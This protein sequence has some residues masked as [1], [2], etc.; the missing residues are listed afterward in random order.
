MGWVVR[1][2]RIGGIGFLWPNDDRELHLLTRDRK[3]GDVLFHA[4]WNFAETIASKDHAPL[5]GAAFCERHTGPHDFVATAVG[6]CG[7]GNWT[8]GF[9]GEAPVPLTFRELRRVALI[10]PPNVFA[11][12]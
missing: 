7:K 9:I 11:K 5:E 1:A 6:Y 4:E 8:V 3:Q 10:S 12:Q 2:A